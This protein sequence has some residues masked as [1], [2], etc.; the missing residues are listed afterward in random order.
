LLVVIAIIAIL[1]AI[2]LPVFAQA[3]EKARQSNCASNLKQIGTAMLMYCQDNDG[4]YLPTW[5]EWHVDLMPYVKNDQIIACPSS[6]HARPEP[7]AFNAYRFA[8]GSVRTGTYLSN[9]VPYGAARP[10]VYG[11]YAKNQEALW[12]Y[13]LLN[14]GHSSDAKMTDAAGTLMFGEAVS[15]PEDTD[16]DFAAGAFGNGPYLEPGGTTWNEVFNMIS[17]RHNG[18]SN[19]LF[20]DGHAKWRTYSWI[21]SQEGKHAVCAARESYTSTAAW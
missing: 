13:G 17:S 15:F 1:A 5:Y 3:R 11:H 2:L 9:T 20:C 8:D 18:G 14:G 7:V 10:E 6:G 12:N 19:G 4:G 16:G 21:Q